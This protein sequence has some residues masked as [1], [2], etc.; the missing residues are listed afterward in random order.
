MVA[1]KKKASA[2]FTLLKCFILLL[3]IAG[4]CAAEYAIVYYGGVISAVLFAAI[5]LL[6]WIMP[7]V[8]RTAYTALAKTAFEVRSAWERGNTYPIPKG[9]IGKKFVLAFLP[10]WIIVPLFLILPEFLGMFIVIPGLVIAV[11]RIERA[12]PVFEEFGISK[13]KYVGCHLLG[14][15]FSFAVFIALTVWMEYVR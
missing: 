8:A 15:A 12:Y 13:K 11:L 9:F 1:P 6:V 5:L 14:Y 3:G 10:F 7:M 2:F 4:F